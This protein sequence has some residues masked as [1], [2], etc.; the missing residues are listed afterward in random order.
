VLKRGTLVDARLVAAGAEVRKGA[1]G[2]KRMNDPAAGFCQARGRPFCGCK[3]HVAVDAGSGLVR[4]RQPA[5]RPIRR[6]Q[7]KPD[8][9]R[10]DL[11]LRRPSR[12]RKAPALR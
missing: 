4:R 2:R 1:E 6:C 3:V 11:H 7:P 12:G 9:P 8:P 5:T 10:H